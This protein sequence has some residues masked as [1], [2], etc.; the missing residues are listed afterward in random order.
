M[1]KIVQFPDNESDYTPSWAQDLPE[2]SYMTMEE[3]EAGA[4]IEIHPFEG[5]LAALKTDLYTGETEQS[6]VAVR[7]EGCSLFISFDNDTEWSID[8]N[9]LCTLIGDTPF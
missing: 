6:I 9:E 1:T 5:N 3:Y 2:G 7:R 4:P 8:Y